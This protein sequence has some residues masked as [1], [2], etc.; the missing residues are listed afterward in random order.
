[1]P[2]SLVGPC[3]VTW[4]SQASRHPQG[5]GKARSGGEGGEGCPL[6][7][8]PAWPPGHTCLCSSALTPRED[9][10]CSQCPWRRAAPRWL[11][12]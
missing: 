11:S 6:A 12:F 2:T 10:C 9:S 5:T 7:D 8:G 1:M 3:P 4:S